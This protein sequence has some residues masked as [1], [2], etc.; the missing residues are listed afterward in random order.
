L[1]AV[2]KGE[3]M[4][5]TIYFARCSVG[6]SKWLWVTYLSHDYLSG[7][8]PF[9]F[10]YASSSVDAE[11]QALE[12]VHRQF[13]ESNTRQVQAYFAQ[14]L[15]RRMAA[16]RKAG[17]Q[18]SSSS[19]A[20]QEFV[21]RDIYCDYGDDYSVRHR[22]V[23]RTRLK[24]FVDKESYRDD[25]VINGD[26]R[27]FAYQRTVALDRTALE[28]DGSVWSRRCGNRFY[29]TPKDQRSANFLPACAV[30]LGL[31]MPWTAEEA[32]R[33]FRALVKTAHPDSGGSN[34]E[35]RKLHEA[36]GEAKR[37]ATPVR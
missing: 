7:N 8:E 12:E 35:F 16:K 11:A 2:T 4:D 31:T 5:D 25:G 27:D 21:F 3:N 24:V 33:A 32:K 36:Y 34:D 1:L 19:A 20:P 9:A 18:S 29:T 17:K 6:K 13:P 28:R 30:V 26:W 14:S 22:I 23:K 15:R 10:G 37:L